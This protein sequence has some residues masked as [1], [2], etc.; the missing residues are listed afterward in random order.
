MEVEV[1]EGIRLG[2]DQ[3]IPCG[4]IVNELVSNSLKHAFPSGQGCVSVSFEVW[5]T[6]DG[7]PGYCM[8]VEDDGKGMYHDV[9]T[10]GSESLGLKLVDLLVQQLHANLKIEAAATDDRPG[11]RYTIEFAARDT[12]DPL[13]G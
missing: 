13:V 2:I 3:A 5:E 4:L 11:L 9:E 12:A 6:A 7:A 8:R 10:Q 1:D